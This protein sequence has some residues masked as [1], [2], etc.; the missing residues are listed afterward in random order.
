[1]NVKTQIAVLNNIIEKIILKVNIENKLK[2]DFSAVIFERQVG[3]KTELS[4]EGYVVTSIK[5]KASIG[6]DK[7]GT[8][9]EAKCDFMGINIVCI[10]FFMG[11][12]TLI[13][14]NRWVI[15]NRQSQ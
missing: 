9:V 7:K 3:F 4:A 6:Q 15:E 10:C 12:Y 8:F 5:P 14:I 13:A 2:K 1:M 11:I